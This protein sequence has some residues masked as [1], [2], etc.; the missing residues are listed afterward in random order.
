MRD[1][2][3]NDL[4]IYDGHADSWWS[5]EVRWLRTLRNMVPGRL[6]WFDRHVVWPGRR[7]LDLGCG[8]GF[9][10]EALAARGARV[11][12][13]D[14]AA[15][16]VAAAARHAAQEGLDIAYLAGRGEALPF[17]DAAF[18]IVVCV[19][20]LEHVDDPARVL[21]EAARVLAPGGSFLFDT[22]NRTALARFGAVTMAE[23]VIRLLPRGAHDPAMFLTPDEMRAHLD[24]A[25]LAPGRFAGLGPRGV[26][27]RGD[28]RFGPWP[29]LAVQYMGLARKP[30]G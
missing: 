17:A 6:R 16:A 19:D 30:R 12:G 21:A 7:V 9:M 29:S 27:R 26:D 18:D 11:T 22:I 10:A 28:L 8:G 4:T 24:A 14:P 1:P 20:V 2:H 3:A 5:D 15:K 25:G 13:L 23:R